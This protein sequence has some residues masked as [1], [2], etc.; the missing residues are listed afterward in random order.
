MEFMSILQTLRCLKSMNAVLSS[1]PARTQP[2]RSAKLLC[3]T[4]LLPACLWPWALTAWPAR[5]A[6]QSGRSWLSQQAGFPVRSH[7]AAGCRLQPSVAPELFICIRNSDNC[8]TAVKPRS[9]WSACRQCHAWVNLKRPC[10]A[11]AK[12]FLS[13]ICTWLQGTSCRKVDQSL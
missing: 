7:H 6:C 9:R 2:L 8:R 12:T 3:P 11:P 4:M 10:A 5:R 13:S 1:V